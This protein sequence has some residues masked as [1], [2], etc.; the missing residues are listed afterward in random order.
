MNALTQL[1]FPSD[2]TKFFRMLAELSKRVAHGATVFK[3]FVDTYAR[4]PQ[5]ER[6]QRVADIKEMEHQVDELAHALMRQLHMSNVGAV[7]REALHASATLLMRTMDA[8]SVAGR[9]M[10]LYRLQFTDVELQQLAL[11]ANNACQ[12]VHSLILQ[13]HE[14]KHLQ[15]T[16]TRIHGLETEA[17]YVYN[18]AMA[19]LFSK[20]RDARELIIMKELYDI[21]EGVADKANYTAIALENMMAREKAR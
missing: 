12:E 7:R 16:L 6:S 2:D 17:D 21:L 10:V 9:R 3:D 11:L 1:L 13:M 4:L 15:K 20:K 14:P 5:K 8:M 18:L 19:K